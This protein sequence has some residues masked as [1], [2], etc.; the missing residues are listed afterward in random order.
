MN[1]T[2]NYHLPQ[3][4]ETDKIMMQDFNQAMADIDA[5][6]AGE[7]SA[8]EQAVANLSQ[9]TVQAQAAA[10]AELLKK[11]RRS[12]YDLYQMAG[13]AAR[14]DLFSFAARGMIINTLHTAT[15]LAQAGT[16]CHMPG[17]VYRLV[18]LLR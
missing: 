15:E 6:I 9:S 14:S 7:K 13:R 10:K 18:P 11:L 2:S 17:G 12:G 4:V 8:R 3:W 5:G 1:Y 16:C